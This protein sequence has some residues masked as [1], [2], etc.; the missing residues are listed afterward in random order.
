MLNIYWRFLCCES[1][2]PIDEVEPKTAG[3]GC[4]LS[5]DFDRFGE[6]A[7]IT[8]WRKYDGCPECDAPEPMIYGR[9]FVIE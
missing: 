5:E 2:I 7:K 1:R 4:C 9:E 8:K 3:K 6:W